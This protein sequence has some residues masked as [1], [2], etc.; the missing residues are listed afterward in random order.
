MPLLLIVFCVLLLIIIS[1]IIIQFRNNKTIIINERDSL[2]NERDSLKNEN[3]LLKNDKQKIEIELAKV[4]GELQSFKDNKKQ[5][6]ELTKEMKSAFENLSNNALREQNK[7][8]KEG[9]EEL[10]KPFKEQITNCKTSIDKMNEISV[11]A[12]TS[13]NTNIENMLKENQRILE[14]ADTVGKSADN[15]ANAFRGD[16]KAQGKFG[17]M[18]LKNLFDSFGLTEGIDF[19]LQYLLRDKN[20]DKKLPDFVVKMPQNKWLVVDSKVSLINYDRYINETDKEK[21][22]KFLKDYFGDIEKHIKELG[23]KKYQKI[24]Q[25]SGKE[26]VNFVCMF[27]PLEQ[28]YIDALSVDRASFF[29]LSSDYKVAVVT[30]SSLSPVL[31][32]ISQLWSMEKMSKNMYE[33]RDTIEKLYDKLCNF[34]KSMQKIK[35][36]LNTANDSYDEAIKQ[37][38]T[39]GKNGKDNVIYLADKAIKQIGIQPKKEITEPKTQ[40]LFEQQKS[41]K[42]SEEKK[43]ESVADDKDTNEQIDD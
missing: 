23:D 1:F 18:Q 20:D 25:S 14:H 10:L 19:F 40:E 3:N 5:Q 16:K 21:K 26:T 37:L 39:G 29:K 35:N 28:A 22:E 12:K 31:Q 7:T 6:E 30:A 4:Q 11:I 36:A 24:L 38:Q 42:A 32:M 13:I 9:I 41:I 15:L 34:T 17:E 27:L 43:N 33:A 8:N 2:K